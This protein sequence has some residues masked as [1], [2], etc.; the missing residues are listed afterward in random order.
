[1]NDTNFV[2]CKYIRTKQGSHPLT[3]ITQF[4]NPLPDV[5]MRRSGRFWVMD[6][7]YRTEGETFLVH[8][9]DRAAQPGWFNLVALPQ[10]QRVVRLPQRPPRRP[11]VPPKPV[12]QEVTKPELIPEPI[13]EAD[14][15]DLQL[16]PGVT[17]EIAE[18]LSGAG[19]VDADTIKSGGKAGLEAIKGIGEAKAAMILNAVQP[20]PA[21]VGTDVI[22]ELEALLGVSAQ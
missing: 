19:Y 8:E 11:P 20:V 7:G 2:M 17:A 15:F 18:R 9:M 5:K 22:A 10:A 1:M 12:W 21:K 16:L 13:P 3:G 14:V 4:V 6:Y